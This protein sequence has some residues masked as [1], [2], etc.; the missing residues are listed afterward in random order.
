M[1]TGKYTLSDIPKTDPGGVFYFL[2]QFR[3]IY[4]PRRQGSADLDRNAAASVPEYGTCGSERDR[5]P[6]F[7]DHTQADRRL[8]DGQGQ[9]ENLSEGAH[10]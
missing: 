10:E 2:L 7:S 3:I 8:Q 9:P 6:S 4:I 5:K 1:N